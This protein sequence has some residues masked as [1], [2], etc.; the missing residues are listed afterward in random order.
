MFIYLFPV[1]YFHGLVGQ[2]K[3]AHHGLLDYISLFHC[4]SMMECSHLVSVLKIDQFLDHCTQSEVL[5][6][7]NLIF[8][9]FFNQ[10]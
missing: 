7:H 5:V 6:Q 1:F 8:L 3:T 10:I 4:V 9:I 2:V